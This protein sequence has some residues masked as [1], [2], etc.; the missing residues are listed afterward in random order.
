MANEPRA[1]AR[2]PENGAAQRRRWRTYAAAAVGILAL[3][4][5]LQNSQDVEVDF[6]FA[7]TTTPLFFVLLIAI[8]LGALIGWLLPRVR[9]HRA[10]R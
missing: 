9:R 5:V 4:F 2:Q 1:G 3:I 6:I 8:A 10:D 7:T